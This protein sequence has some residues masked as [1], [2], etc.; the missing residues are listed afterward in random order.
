MSCKQTIIIF[1]AAA[2]CLSIGADFAHAQSSDELQPRGIEL[3]VL[4]FHPG[5]FVESTYDSNYFYQDAGETLDADF[6]DVLVVK[7]GISARFELPDPGPTAWTFGARASWEQYLGLD[8]EVSTG[9][10]EAHLDTTLTLFRQSLVSLIPKLA[11][12]RVNG[13]ADDFLRRNYNQHTIEPG[14]ELNIQP[15]GGTV[16]SQRIGWNLRGRFFDDVDDLNNIDN[17]FTAATKWNFL[18]Q[19]AFTLLLEQRIVSY[20]TAQRTPSASTNFTLENVNS[21]PFRVMA[22]LQGLLLDRLDVTLLGGYGYTFYDGGANEHVPMGRAELGYKFLGDSRISLGWV[23]DFG[24]SSFGNYYVFD[25]FYASFQTHFLHRFSLELS[26][27]VNLQRFAAVAGVG[28]R[29]DI[30]YDVDAS[31]SYIFVA[32]LT[33]RLSYMLRGDETDFST[34]VDGRTTSGAYTKHLVVL[35]LAYEY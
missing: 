27:K 14:L 20:L 30:L 7:P 5:A 4:R 12:M 9:G 3:G 35:N 22:G 24:D 32:G 18:P 33:A 17:R 11:Y 21:T 34:T 29:S 13:P 15:E 8:N 26:P 16:F 6:A 25:R 10:A 1:I 19:T 28:E 23:H 31:L 2:L